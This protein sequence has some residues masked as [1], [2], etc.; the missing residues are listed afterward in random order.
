MKDI[1]TS[2]WESRPYTRETAAYPV[3]WLKEKKFWPT[4]TR[5]DD[6]KFKPDVLRCC[7][8]D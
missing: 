3:S 8:H 2:D 7:E 1:V 6:G 5:L 4:V